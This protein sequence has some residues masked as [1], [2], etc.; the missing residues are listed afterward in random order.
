LGQLI[1][2]GDA[3]TFELMAQQD[4]HFMLMKPEVELLDGLLNDLRSGF[5]PNAAITVSLQVN[6]RNLVN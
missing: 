1:V 2:L 6:L 5:D 3:C 4:Q